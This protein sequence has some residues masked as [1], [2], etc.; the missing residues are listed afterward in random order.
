MDWGRVPR[1]SVLMF[2]M[3]VLQFLYDLSD[4]DIEEHRKFWQ[5]RPII[6]RKFAGCKQFPGLRE[7]ATGGSPK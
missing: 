4:R 3:L 6:E 2:K 1:A 7:H 5:E